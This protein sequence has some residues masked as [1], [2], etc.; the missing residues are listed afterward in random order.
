MIRTPQGLAT[1]SAG[2]AVSAG[3]VVAVG[4]AGAFVL[5]CGSLIDSP[6]RETS[7]PAYLDHVA[8]VPSFWASRAGSDLVITFRLRDDRPPSGVEIEALRDVLHAAVSTWRDPLRAAGRRVDL[9]VVDA[10]RAGRPDGP[11]IEVRFV[12]RGEGWLGVTRYDGEQ[13]EI[14]ISVRSVAVDRFLSRREI[15][16]LTLHEVGHAL[17][18]AN[19][20]HSPN[21]NDVMFGHNLQNHWITL[22]EADRAVILALFPE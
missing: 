6:S 19:T 15:L 20:G 22:S 10:T 5:G 17:G 4:V 1:V 13:V 14:E 16:A 2:V 18:I 9:R 12:D 21:A 8:E 7:T 3:A 11:S